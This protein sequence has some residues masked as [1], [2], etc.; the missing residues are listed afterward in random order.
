MLPSGEV[1]TVPLLPTA[2]NDSFPYAIFPKCFL[3]PDF[4]FV[5]VFPSDEVRTV[6]EKPTATKVLLP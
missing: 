6:P 5:H 4:L 1:I 2:T 3:V